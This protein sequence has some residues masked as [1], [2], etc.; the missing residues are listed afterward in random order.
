MTDFNSYLIFY[1]LNKELLTVIRITRKV[2]K[3]ISNQEWTG[4]GP[5]GQYSL[6]SF[7]L[8]LGTTS[9]AK[10]GSSFFFKFTL[11]FFSSILILVI[12][13]LVEMKLC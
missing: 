8:D 13:I 11:K 9:L 4:V 5:R 12:F 7:Q 3:N 2:I 1:S 6:K 10:L